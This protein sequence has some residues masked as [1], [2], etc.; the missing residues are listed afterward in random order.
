ERSLELSAELLMIPATV[1]RLRGTRSSHLEGFRE[2]AHGHRGFEAVAALHDADDL[3]L[4]GGSAE[5]AMGRVEA[6]L[7]TGLPASTQIS[8][9]LL[10]VYLLSYGERHELA[11]RAL[12]AGL[13]RARADGHTA[14]QGV[15]HSQRAAIALA[16]G[17]LHDAQVEAETGLLL[18]E[19]PH[20][21]FLQ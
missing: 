6:A 3:L 5:L 11:L 19:P 10:A 20:R 16:Q 9:P 7:L 13:E 4:G 17:A 14:R 2:Q 12:N 15:I 8:A 21:A 18:V 1:L